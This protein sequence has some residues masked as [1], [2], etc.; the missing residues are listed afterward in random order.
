MS[1]GRRIPDDGPMTY[2]PTEQNQ[3]TE[4]AEPA[5]PG[6]GG[7]DFDRLPP[8]PATSAPPLAAPPPGPD[9]GRTGLVRDP[10]S[11]LGGIASGVAHR[12]GW[13]PT[14]VRLLFVVGLIASG[15]A[16][17]LLYLV[18]WVVI[19]R[20]TVWPPTPVRHPAGGGFSNREAG[21]GIAIAGV[22]A[23]LVAGAG[24]AGAVLVPL[25]LVG[26]GIWL[27]TQPPRAL[28]FDGAGAPGSPTSSSGAPP[29]VPPPAPPA[30]AGPVGQ[31]VPPR[32]RRRKWAVRALVAAAVL[33]VLA[34]VV[35]PVAVVAAWIGG[36]DGVSVSV[37]NDSLRLSNYAPKSLDALP[38]TIRSDNGLARVDLSAIPAADFAE[39]TTPA[40]LDIAIGDG[41]VWLEVPDGVSY[42][43]DA[44]ADEGTI[45]TSGSELDDAR[46]DRHTVR[47]DDEDPD[48][49]I[50]IEVDQ[51]DVNLT[52]N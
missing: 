15:G 13:D 7:E 47:V 25:A 38:S 49:I 27:L 1:L 10:Y 11:R 14:L 17:L 29:P 9:A 22:L 51:G 2:E 24:A 48:I 30:P 46:I 8:P 50:T 19:P 52:E 31:P 26:G 33:T 45:H 3:P 42:S 43:L 37:G 44:T 23:F 40:R 36:G 6:S 12:Y 21:L 4:P 5:E 35:V 20:A 28:G 41:E 16:A 34:A 18:A 39:R 32:S